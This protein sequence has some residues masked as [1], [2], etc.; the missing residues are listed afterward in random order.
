MGLVRAF[1]SCSENFRS[2]FRYRNVLRNRYIEPRHLTRKKNLDSGS[3][4]GTVSA[5]GPLPLTPPGLDFAFG[6]PGASPQHPQATTSHRVKD[7]DHSPDHIP[8]PQFR[9]APSR[10][11]C[12]LPVP[13]TY[14]GSYRSVQSVRLG[15]NPAAIQRVQPGGIMPDGYLPDSNSCRLILCCARFGTQKSFRRLS[16]TRSVS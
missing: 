15:R 11:I 3:G 4:G 6:E 12:S 9:P 5:K 8:H 13:W 7:E 1:C 2:H 16:G 14:Y 10:S